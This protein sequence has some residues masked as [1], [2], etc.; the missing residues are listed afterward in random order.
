MGSDTVCGLGDFVCSDTVCS[1]TVCG[2]GHFVC[3]DTVSSDTVG[4]CVGSDT[5][6]SSDTEFGHGGLGDSDRGIT[7]ICLAMV[8]NIQP[9]NVG[10]AATCCG[11]V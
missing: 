2:L 10:N 4:H 3:S 11:I 7:V 9:R 6:V 1:D 5:H 8:L